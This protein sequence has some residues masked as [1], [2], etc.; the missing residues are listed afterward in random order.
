MYSGLRL[1]KYLMLDYEYHL[2]I[3]HGIQRINIRKKIEFHHE[4]QPENLSKPNSKSQI[5]T[6]NHRFRY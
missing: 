1:I 3:S 6:D 5:F 4:K 2:Q